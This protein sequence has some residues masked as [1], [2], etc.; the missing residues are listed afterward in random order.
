MLPELFL[1]L[2]LPSNTSQGVALRLQ[3][4][5]ASY[6]VRQLCDF[7]CHPEAD[8]IN[9]MSIE[10]NTGSYE[11]SNI[12][13]LRRNSWLPLPYPTKW[14]M[15]WRCGAARHPG[16]DIP[17]HSCTRVASR[18]LCRRRNATST[19]RTGCV[20]CL[21]NDVHLKVCTPCAA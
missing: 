21:A 10:V 13:P 4:G 8:Q 20:C 5:S 6:R 12:A 1:C 2:T 19:R 14:H 15:D 18:F 17:H 11:Y 16:T 7:L 3:N 9:V